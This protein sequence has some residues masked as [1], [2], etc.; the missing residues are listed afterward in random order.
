MT[1]WRPPGFRSRNCD[2]AIWSSPRAFSASHRPP[3][4]PCHTPQVTDISQNQEICMHS[5]RGVNSVPTDLLKYMFLLNFPCTAPS[6][7]S[8]KAQ[9]QPASASQAS[10]SFSRQPQ[11]SSDAP[12]SARR[13]AAPLSEPG[14]HLSPEVAQSMHGTLSRTRGAQAFRAI[15]HIPPCLLANASQIH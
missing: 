11:T 12:G 14:N 7:R 5:Y 2:Q 1:P 10:H 9:R 6:N 8:R 13:H 4:L 15:Q 3:A